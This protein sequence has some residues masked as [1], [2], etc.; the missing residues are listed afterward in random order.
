MS[1]RGDGR[2]VA[3]CA[4]GPFWKDRSVRDVTIRGDM[5]R[6]GQLLKLAGV[7]DSGGEAKQLLGAGLVTVNGE[8]EVR[9][10]RQL[11]DGD[12]VAAEGDEVRVVATD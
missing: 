1:H 2:A 8:E 4:A 3:A 10:G 9:R 7:V 6:L 12:L 5:I 11:H